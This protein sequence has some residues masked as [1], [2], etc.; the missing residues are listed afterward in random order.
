MK[1]IRWIIIAI[2]TVEG[3]T[4]LLRVSFQVNFFN[5]WGYPAWF[6]YVVGLFELAGAVGLYM[7]KSRRYANIALLLFMIGAFY[8][9]LKSGDAIQMMS[10]AMVTTILLGIHFMK[11][12]RSSIPQVAPTSQNI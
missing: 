4:K 2:F 12:K 11:L 10:L 6:M 9:H 8:T 7:E 1:I 3:I 5:H